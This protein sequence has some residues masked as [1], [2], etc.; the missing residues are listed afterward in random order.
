[1]PRGRQ[2]ADC[3]QKHFSHKSI[4]IDLQHAEEGENRRSR[5][6]AEAKQTETDR[7]QCELRVD[8]QSARGIYPLLPTPTTSPS[9]FLPH[10]FYNESQR[11]T[12][13]Y[14]ASETEL[15]SVWFMQRCATVFLPLGLVWAIY[16]KG[17]GRTF[18]CP[19]TSL[20]FFPCLHFPF[21]TL[22]RHLALSA[23]SFCC[24][25]SSYLP[26]TAANE[27]WP[28]RV[29]V[30]SMTWHCHLLYGLAPDP[31]SSLSLCLLPP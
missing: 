25:C 14:L 4:K 19:R 24:C 22:L 10:N 2:Q 28:V 29:A 15:P 17:R 1:M 9:H 3:S 31:A 8:F 5:G 16:M 26:E 30:A 11:S 7:T 6:G 23:A 21:S 13:N 27:A 12:G 20:P 18:A